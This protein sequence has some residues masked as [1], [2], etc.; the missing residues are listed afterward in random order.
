M[1]RL[2]YITIAVL[3]VLC[4]FVACSNEEQE[5][6]TPPSSYVVV[7][8]QECDVTIQ[9]ASQN[10]VSLIE[11]KLGVKLNI[12]TD[13]TAEASKEILIG[14]TNRNAS[15]TTT[16]LDKGQ[17]LVFSSG[18]KIVLKGQG[19]YIGSACSDLVHKYARATSD[20]ELDISAVPTHQTA[21]TYT[22]DATYRNVIFMIGDGM[23]E[24]HIK[25]TEQAGACDFVARDFPNIGL[26]ITRSQS[27]INKEA[28]YTDSAASASAMATGYKTINGYVGVDQDG[29]PLKNI[30][31]LAFEAGAKTAVV[32]TDLITGATPA[33][34]MCHSLSRENTDEI[35]A[36]INALVAEGKISYCEGNVG[37]EL[38]V[39]TKNALNTISANNSQFFIMIEEGIID[40]R[41]HDKD[42]KGAIDTVRRFNDAVAYATQFALCHPDTV[43]IV[44]ADHETGALAFNATSEYGYVFTSYNHTNTNVP[45]FALGAGT[46]VFN[47]ARVENTE[48]AKFCAKAY[49]NEGF[50][51]QE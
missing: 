33:S 1:K 15:K 16:P 20:G 30:R 36:Q 31:E 18:E 9:Y 17:Y 25:M 12:V 24:N 34:Y 39:H 29:N 37:D 7:I 5:P 27:V 22:P 14:E 51:Q 23:G 26:S 43:L 6:S 35:S 11:E 45:I 3:L 50:G 8:P 13:S 40:K 19:I 21:F 10:L 38:T 4:S 46:Q 49:S 28:S 47:G 42:E 41:S 2:L 44:T 48:L 32:T